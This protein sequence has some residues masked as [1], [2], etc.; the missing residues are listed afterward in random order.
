MIALVSHAI[1][2]TAVIAA[3]WIGSFVA[4]AAVVF[5]FF[6]CV[7]CQNAYRS[8][9]EKHAR[10]ASSAPPPAPYMIGR[11]MLKIEAAHP[12]P[13]IAAEIK[14]RSD[15]TFSG[16]IVKSTPIVHVTEITWHD[17]T[18]QTVSI[19]RIDQRRAE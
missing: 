8:A 14:Q 1:N 12:D 10:P 15:R 13:K 4:I 16:R 17:G 18:K 2:W 3:F 5:L 7:A 19:S 9:R 11:P 6:A